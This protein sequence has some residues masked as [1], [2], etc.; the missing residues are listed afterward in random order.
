MGAWATAPG[1]II[2]AVEESAF[3]QTDRLY[4]QGSASGQVECPYRCG[5]HMFFSFDA[6]C[7]FRFRCPHLCCSGQSRD[8]VGEGRDRRRLAANGHISLTDRARSA[9]DRNAR[10]AEISLGESGRF[11]DGAR[12]REFVERKADGRAGG[13]SNVSGD[14]SPGRPQGQRMR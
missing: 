6:G 12:R 9:D 10:A 5:M 3:G 2:G 11:Q 7:P 4:P 13:A 1:S 14:V 8:T